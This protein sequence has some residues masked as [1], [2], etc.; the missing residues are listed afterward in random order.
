MSL[1]DRLE[2]IPERDVLLE[3]RRLEIERGFAPVVVRHLLHSLGREGLRE[4]SVLHRAVD[5]HASAVRIAPRNLG[6]CLLASNHGEWRLQRINVM[7]RLDLL[8]Q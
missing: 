7:K 1:G 6:R 2:R 3:T 4:N 8:Q 5:Y